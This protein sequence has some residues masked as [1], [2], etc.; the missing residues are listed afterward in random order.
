M[1][2]CE[3]TIRFP[4]KAILPTV[5]KKMDWRQAALEELKPVKEVAEAIKERYGSDREERVDW[6]HNWEAD[7]TGLGGVWT[8]KEGHRRLG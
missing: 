2:N 8:G 6:R 7:P 3:H 5:L 1:E 4:S